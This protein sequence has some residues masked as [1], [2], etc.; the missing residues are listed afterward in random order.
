MGLA[1]YAKKE[2]IEKKNAERENKRFSSNLF[3]LR[4]L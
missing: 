3:S 4:Q 2:Y 1:Q